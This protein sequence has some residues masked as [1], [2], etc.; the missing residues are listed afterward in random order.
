MK[1]LNLYSCQLLSH[2]CRSIR[3]EGFRSLIRAPATHTTNATTFFK[4]PLI[5]GLLQPFSVWGADR[6]IKSSEI[7][8][9]LMELSSPFQKGTA[10]MNSFSVDNWPSKIKR[11]GSSLLPP[12]HVSQPFAYI[13][14]KTVIRKKGAKQLYWKEAGT[15]ETEGE[16]GKRYR[17]REQEESDFWFNLNRKFFWKRPRILWL[18]E[19]G[20]LYG[21]EK[22]KRNLNVE[23][24]RD[25]DRFWGSVL[26]ALFLFF[27][28][29]ENGKRE[30]EAD[31]KGGGSEGNTKEKIEKK[32]QRGTEIVY[33]V[34]VLDSWNFICFVLNLFIWRFICRK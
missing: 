20:E 21:K 25:L 27:R 23:N 26:A 17:E 18:N 33:V 14:M 16:R 8:W 15:R 10:P 7:I 4:P 34:F 5:S 19:K 6:N 9:S 31:T 24:G 2:Q 29:P 30:I 12:L 22:R 11:P 28:S 32:E 3:Y 1:A 13:Q